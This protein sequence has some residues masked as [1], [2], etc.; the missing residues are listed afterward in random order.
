MTPTDG[1]G[2]RAT[3]GDAVGELATVGFAVGLEDGVAAAEQPTSATDRTRN[4]EALR[5][6]VFGYTHQRRTWK[7]TCS[8]VMTR[9]NSRRAPRTRRG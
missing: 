7:E 1:E 6:A 9:G 5:I 2:G 4:H 3:D 8:E